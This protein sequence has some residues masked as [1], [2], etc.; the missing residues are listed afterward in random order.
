MWQTTDKYGLIPEEKSCDMNKYEM[1]LIFKSN[2]YANFIP[3]ASDWIS[4]KLLG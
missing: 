4:L 2:I 1:K 3:I